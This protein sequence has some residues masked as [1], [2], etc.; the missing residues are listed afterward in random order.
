MP[1]ESLL[2]LLLLLEGKKQTLL[3]P[4]GVRSPPLVTVGL[5]K[6]LKSLQHAKAGSKG[7]KSFQEIWELNSSGRLLTPWHPNSIAQVCEKSGSDEISCVQMIVMMPVA[8]QFKI[9]CEL[10]YSW[11]VVVFF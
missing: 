5:Q 8:Q 2:L 10:F 11:T 9:I 1:Y 3:W 4:F 7:R 6:G